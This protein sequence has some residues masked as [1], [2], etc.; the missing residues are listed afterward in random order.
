MVPVGAVEDPGG[1]HHLIKANLEKKLEGEKTKEI[2]CNELG[3]RE[4]LVGFSPPAFASL[5]SILPTGHRC[6]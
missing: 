2:F 4:Q 3:I 1:R 5:Q 6:H